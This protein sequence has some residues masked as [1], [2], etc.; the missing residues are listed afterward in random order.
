MGVMRIIMKGT[1]VKTSKNVR[2]KTCTSRG[3]K[4]VPNAARKKR[5][6]EVPMSEP[7]NLTP[8][9]RKVPASRMVSNDSLTVSD[10]RSR[11]ISSDIATL[12]SSEM[13]NLDFMSGISMANFDK[14]SSSMSCDCWRSTRDI[15]LRKDKSMTPNSATMRRMSFISP[16]ESVS[17]GAATSSSSANMMRSISI[18]N[19]RTAKT[20]RSVDTFSSLSRILSPSATRE[21][22][23]LRPCAMMASRARCASVNALS[24]SC[25]SIVRRSTR[26]SRFSRGTLG[27]GY[28][29]KTSTTPESPM[30]S[31]LIR[32]QTPREYCAALLMD[33]RGLALS[34]SRPSP[35]TPSA[36][37]TRREVNLP[38][39]RPSGRNLAPTWV[40]P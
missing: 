21:S 12:G 3:R 26:A 14:A 28:A 16:L 32:A 15:N 29:F 11:I 23:E 30:L 20:R 36:L 22:A 18:C 31:P 25:T 1:N 27:T 10:M 7:S 9:T 4:V 2:R 33:S 37:R 19:V 13:A 39:L 6:T 17:G 24:L 35:R 34:C 8:R 5:R 40:S 38:T